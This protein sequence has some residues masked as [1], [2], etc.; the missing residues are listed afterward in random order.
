MWIR[1][2]AIVAVKACTR[3]SVKGVESVVGVTSWDTD[4]G[5]RVLEV[6]ATCPIISIETLVMSS[7]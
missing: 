5:Q 7:Q 2:H 6:V 3:A 4:A 1:I